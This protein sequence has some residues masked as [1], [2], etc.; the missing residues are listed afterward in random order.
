MPKAAYQGVLNIGDMS[1]PCAVLEDGRRVISEMGILSNLGTTGGKGRK[2]RKELEQQIEAPIH[3]FLA[4]KA[5]EPFIYK[6]FDEGNLK[7][8]DPS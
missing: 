5:L 4:S 6:V 2:I 1:I 3:I 7:V 8:I